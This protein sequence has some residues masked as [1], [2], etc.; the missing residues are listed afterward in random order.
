MAVNNSFNQAIQI[1]QSKEYQKWYQQQVAQAQKNAQDQMTQNQITYAPS[2]TTTG[3]AAGYV[4]VGSA[5]N[6]GT[7]TL[8][9][10]GQWAVAEDLIYGIDRL[11]PEV[12]KTFRDLKSWV[13]GK[14]AQSTRVK[15]CF[16]GLKKATA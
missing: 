16:R 2:V 11:A 14:K 15:R 13:E 5:Y 3:I 8:I 7:N 10:S 12:D 1:S 4:Q 9:A 6:L